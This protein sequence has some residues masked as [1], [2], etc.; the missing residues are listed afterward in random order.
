MNTG[1]ASSLYLYKISDVT[2]CTLRKPIVNV[3][4]AAPPGWDGLFCV[5]KPLVYPASSVEWKQLKGAHLLT[6]WLNIRKTVDCE[7]L[8][9]VH[10]RE[11]KYTIQSWNEQPPP[12]KYYIMEVRTGYK[13][14]HAAPGR[15]IW[16]ILAVFDGFLTGSY[17]FA[18]ACFNT[19]TF[20]LLIEKADSHSFTL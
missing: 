7:S 5:Y 17:F 18:C 11:W 19:Y 20:M 12:I 6:R 15:L 9:H 4:I 16:Y 14:G 2:T 8:S 3:Q 13:K 1:V 10:E